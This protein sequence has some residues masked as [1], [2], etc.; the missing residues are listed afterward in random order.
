MAASPTRQPGAVPV[1][2]PLSLI[3]VGLKEAALDSPS[4]R[5]TVVHFSDQI[6]AVEKWLDGYVKAASKLA[7]EVGVLEDVVNSF[8]TASNPPDSLS[9]AA[10]DHDYTVL[11]MRRYG[12]GAHEFWSCLLYTSPSPRD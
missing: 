2:K 6:D 12:Q 11:A 4:F 8:L 10:L 3:P 7:Q 5:S 1:T 9:E